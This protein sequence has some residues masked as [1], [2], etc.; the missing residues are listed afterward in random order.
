MPVRSKAQWKKMYVLFQQG[1]ITRS[2]LDDF[3]NGVSYRKLPAKKAR[4]GS[5][6]KRRGKK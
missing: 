4:Q 1:K 2:E 6:K 5:P 3:V